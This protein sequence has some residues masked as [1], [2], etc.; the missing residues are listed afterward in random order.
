MSRFLTI[1]IYVPLL[2]T[3][4]VG[5]SQTPAVLREGQRVRVAYRCKV[6]HDHV[7]ECRENR[8][9]RLDT[10]HLQSLDSDTLRIREAGS[11]A[12]LAIPTVS[13]AELWVLEG[14]KGNFWNGAGIGLVAGALVGGIIGSK[15]EFCIFDCSAPSGGSPLTLVGV[16]VGAPAGALL[17]GIVGSQIRSDRWRQLPV[18]HLGM[19]FDP[20]LGTIGLRVSVAF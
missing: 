3:P 18:N 7:I 15:Q 14:R 6:A 17:G 1:F 13:I 20:R 5:S 4:N 8:S 9:P 12:E 16:I 10:G 11:D 19:T 2:F